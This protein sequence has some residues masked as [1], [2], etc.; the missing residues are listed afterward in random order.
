M[1]LSGQI[2]YDE[3][4]ALGEN[5]YA[6]TIAVA[7]RARQLHDGEKPLTESVVS[8]P[9]TIALKEFRE[10]RLRYTSSVSREVGGRVRLPEEP[11]K[12]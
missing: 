11:E 7:R 10:G 2:S 1:L 4:M 9:V 12:M 8:K 6:L 5:K 3:L